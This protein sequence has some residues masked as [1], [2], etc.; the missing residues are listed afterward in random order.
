MTGNVKIKY[1]G[2]EK[3]LKLQTRN[4][5]WESTGRKRMSDDKQN[6]KRKLIFCVKANPLRNISHKVTENLQ[7]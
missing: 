6:R 2:L 4:S 5:D 3:Q 1:Y 7:E